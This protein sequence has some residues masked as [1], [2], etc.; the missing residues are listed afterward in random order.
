MYVRNAQNFSVVLFSVKTLET[1]KDLRSEGVEKLIIELE[2]FFGDAL[3]HGDFMTEQ[4]LRTKVSEILAL[5]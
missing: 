5:F 3:L 2:S 4:E 1:V